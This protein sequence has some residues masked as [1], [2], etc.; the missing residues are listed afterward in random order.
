MDS[1]DLVGG[2]NL[3]NPVRDRYWSDQFHVNFGT[4][5]LQSDKF[6]TD[7]L[8]L[9]HCDNDFFRFVIPQC[10]SLRLSQFLDSG[11][12]VLTVI[13]AFTDATAESGATAVFEKGIKRMSPYFRAH[14]Q[15]F[16][17]RGTTTR[18]G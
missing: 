10:P 11:E 3:I 15:R 18:K 1:C 17:K 2:E 8:R 7:D 16:A 9:V 6:K 13:L 4:P 14:P 12:C 5:R